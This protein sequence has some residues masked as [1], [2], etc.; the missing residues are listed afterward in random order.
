MAAVALALH[1]QGH[2]GASL[3]VLRDNRAARCFYECLGGEVIGEKEDRRG[4]VTL[5]E[6][7]Y[8]CR[9]LSFAAG[10]AGTTPL[11]RSD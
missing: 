3:W 6:L 5:F 2:Q 7:A 4:A 1:D 9:D 10:S 11:K 8:G